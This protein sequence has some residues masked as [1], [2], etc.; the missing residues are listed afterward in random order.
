MLKK[1]KVVLMSDIHIRLF[2]RLDEYSEQFDKVYKILT[3]EAPQYIVLGGDIFHNKNNLS[4]EAISLTS[5]FFRN[6]SNLCEK[7]IIIPGNHDLL[8]N[9]Q[10]RMDSITP[11][12]D[13]LGIE[14]LHYLKN[15]ECYNIGDYVW[16]LWSQIENNTRPKNLE[17]S[18]K[19]NHKKHIG[20]YHGVLN[21]MLTDIGFSFEDGMRSDEFDGMWYTLCGDIH[22]RQI[23]YTSEKRPIIMVGS[24]I[25]QDFGE[26][27]GGHGMCVVD[28]EKDEYSFIDLKSDYG[29]YTFKINSIE[30][31]EEGLEKLV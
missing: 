21:G 30:D 26:S 31:I 29:F 11:I 13:S 14:N 24:L 5:S 15:S 8:T 17:D 22:K 1:N 2:K 23:F 6:L 4:P 28:L 12:V 7:L 25:Q 20:L 3:D 16:C 9:N 27:V 18:L 10:D 19:N